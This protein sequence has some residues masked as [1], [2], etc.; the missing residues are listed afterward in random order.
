[1]S[2]QE[3]IRKLRKQLT[4]AKENAKTNEALNT[5]VQKIEEQLKDLG[6]GTKRICD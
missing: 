3:E 5:E 4:E 6:C 2:N 1:M